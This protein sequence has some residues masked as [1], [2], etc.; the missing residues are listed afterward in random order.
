L[1]SLYVDASRQCTAKL[2]PGYFKLEA[3]CSGDLLMKPTVTYSKLELS[4]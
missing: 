3:S 1:E 2:S 4:Q